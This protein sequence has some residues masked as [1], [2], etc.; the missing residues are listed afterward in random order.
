MK[1]KEEIIDP[2]LLEIDEI[3]EIEELEEDL[4][5]DITIDNRGHLFFANDI[6]T[7]N[8][9]YDSSELNL[10]HI[11]ESAGLSHTSDVIYGIIQ[12]TTMHISN[13][14]FLKLLKIRNGAGKNS[15]CMYRINY[16][17]MRLVETDE[18]L[19]GTL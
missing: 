1:E 17:Y 5:L 6:L 2:S 14:Y 12:D 19:N 3:I 9:G 13:E 10:G 16:Q 11:A 15:R 18:V 7:H 8:S 4:T